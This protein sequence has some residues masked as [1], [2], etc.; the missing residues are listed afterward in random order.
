MGHVLTPHG[1]K[2]DPDKAK[3]GRD[4]P[5]PEDVEGIQRIN[6]FVDYLAKFLP[7]LA[8]DMEPLGQLTRRDTRALKQGRQ[9]GRRRRTG[10]NFPLSSGSAHVTMPLHCPALVVHWKFTT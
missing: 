3:A 4:M 2:M 5:K 1:V 10:S 9:K 7:G 6:G 8:D